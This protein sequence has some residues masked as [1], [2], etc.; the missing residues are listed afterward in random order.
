MY[1][2]RPNIY[3]LARARVIL[4]VENANY[5]NFWSRVLRCM[6]EKLLRDQMSLLD[7]GKI[8]HLQFMKAVSLTFM[9]I[10]LYLL[11]FIKIHM[12]IHRLT[13]HD[14]QMR[15]FKLSKL[16]LRCWD[17]EV[18]WRG[19]TKTTFWE[20]GQTTYSCYVSWVILIALKHSG[21][22]CEALL[23][24]HQHRF[25]VFYFRSDL[26]QLDLEVP[27]DIYQ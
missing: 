7:K 13:I 19:T 22:Q 1:S 10:K 24:T 16:T 14:A 9:P 27:V 6:K 4:D 23:S 20:T 5:A 26:V 8:S 3:N 12:K 21:Y 17:A 18:R 15:C 2:S 25:E 11:N